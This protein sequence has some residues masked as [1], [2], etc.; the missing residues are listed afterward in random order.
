MADVDDGDSLSAGYQQIERG[1]ARVRFSDSDSSNYLDSRESRDDTT[2][3]ERIADEGDEAIRAKMSLSTSESDVS[4]NMDADY[5][6]PSFLKSATISGVTEYEESEDMSPARMD[7]ILGKSKSSPDMI[8]ATGFQ[9]EVEKMLATHM[10]VT[11]L[12]DRLYLSDYMSLSAERLSEL[13]VSLVINATYEVPNVEVPE[14]TIEFIQLHINDSVTADM[15]QH[16]DRCAD[17]IHEVR[18]AG[19]VALVHCALGV[20]RSVTICLA[21]LVKYE[22]RTLREA[23]FEV[24]KKRPI[25]RPNE[26]FW[27]Q[28]IA[29]EVAKR[30]R[31][32]VK[33]SVFPMG[34]IP[35]VYRGAP[36]T[37][38]M[39]RF[40]VSAFELQTIHL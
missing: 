19:G 2:E 33:L 14:G 24:K 13:G 17:R 7:P 37:G 6:L 30:G 11:R 36:Q 29:F 9:T 18:S 1:I 26:G 28:L 3:P 35:D 12:L 23:Y 4:N 15:A 39:R 16:M 31:A 32:T 40:H 20:S 38:K 5:N 34:V 21:Y 8:E 22:G 27:R 10:D 25:I